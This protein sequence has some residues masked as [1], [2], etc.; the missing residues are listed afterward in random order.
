MTISLSQEFVAGPAVDSDSA[1]VAHRTRGNEKR[2]GL[3]Q[4][5][6]D[7]LLE[8]PH[9]GIFVEYVVAHFRRG[10]RLSHRR[11]GAGHRITA[12]IDHGEGWRLEAGGV[13][14]RA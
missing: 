2:R 5:F 14:L 8:P 4:H 1:L 6:G 9:G 3:S 10:H 13:R 12:E 7:S 11:R